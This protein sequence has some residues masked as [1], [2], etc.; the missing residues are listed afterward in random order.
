[1]DQRVINLMRDSLK[2]QGFTNDLLI[3]GI[4]AEAY[5]ETGFVIRSEMSYKNTSVDRLRVIFGSKLSHYSND[6]LTTLKQ[7]DVAFFDVIY[8]GAYGNTAPGDGYKYR[9]R[10]YNQLTFKAGY[11]SVGNGIQ[12]DLVNRP[13]DMLQ[14]SVASLAL[15]EY[16]K[17]T[18]HTAI[19][20][21]TFKAKLGVADLSQVNTIELAVKTA[22]QANAGFGKDL[23]TPFFQSVYQK[24]LAI[25]RQL[26]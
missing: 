20:N 25:A 3:K 15:A 11:Q 2:K 23:N 8:G 1:M 14:E 9:G 16:Y 13:D 26:V 5:T 19:A 18:F 10:G 7:N 17:Q 12:V 24:A 4:I 22:L 21:G 6:Q